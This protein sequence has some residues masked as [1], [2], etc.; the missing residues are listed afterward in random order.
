MAFPQNRMRR[1]RSSGAI[2]RLVCQ[3]N[4]AV[5]DLVYPLFVREGKGLK[6]PIKSMTD[7]FHFSPDTIAGEARQVASLGIPAVL[8]FGLPGKK[9]EIGS[10]AWAEDGVVQPV[11]IYRP[12]SLRCYQ[13]W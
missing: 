6:E 3:T 10:Q 1:L 13:Q 9:D 5:N 4:L 8:L 7:C 11:R 12:R 2:R